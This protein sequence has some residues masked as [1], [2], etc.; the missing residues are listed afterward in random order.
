MNLNGYLKKAIV[1]PSV[2]QRE[3]CNSI[4]QNFLR[5]IRNNYNA[6]IKE[7]NINEKEREIQEEI[8]ERKR[9]EKILFNEFENKLD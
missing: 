7:H 8:N 2:I 5:N 1:P 9:L 6:K 4:N 3:I